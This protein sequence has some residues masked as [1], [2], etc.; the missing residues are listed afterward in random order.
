MVSEESRGTGVAAVLT[1]DAEARLAGKGV[2]I[3]W[4][5]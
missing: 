2:E 3:A 5:A 4:L 1:A